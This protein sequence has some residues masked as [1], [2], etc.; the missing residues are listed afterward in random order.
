MVQDHLCVPGSRVR[1]RGS[2][3]SSVTAYRW[4]SSG[5]SSV[6]VKYTC[7]WLHLRPPT[8]STIQSPPV[9]PG[10]SGCPGLIE[11]QVAETAALRSPEETACLAFI[12]PFEWAKQVV[13]VDPH[14][15]CLAAARSCVGRCSGRRQPAPARSAGGSRSVRSSAHP[16]AS[17]PVPGRYPRSAPRSIQAGSPPSTDN[18][19]QPHAGVSLPGKRIAVVFLCAFAGAI[20]A[21]VDDAVNRDVASHPPPRRRSGGCPA[22]T[23]SRWRAPSLPGRYTPP[24]RW[25]C[26]FPRPI[27]EL[28]RRAAGKGCNIRP[29]RLGHTPPSCHPGKAVDRAPDRRSHRPGGVK[30]ALA[31]R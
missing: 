25:S 13:Q 31:H 27:S 17:R 5:S 28:A 16:A 26:R 11:I 19:A 2:P 29:R 15:G 10:G 8:A 18:H 7:P 22:T 20:L 24:G 9:R 4:H 23:R 12:G 6:A 1:R 30:A 14:R 3:P 21:L